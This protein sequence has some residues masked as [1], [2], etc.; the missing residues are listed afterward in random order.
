MRKIKTSIT[1]SN[2][3]LSEIDHLM[4]K[5]GNRS[6]F[7]ESAIKFYIAQ[8]YKEQRNRHDLELLNAN[9][10]D[11]NKEANDILSYQSIF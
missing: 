8:K 2:E 10:E 4:P 9:Y 7:I 6:S 1:I 11:L 5:N 3:I